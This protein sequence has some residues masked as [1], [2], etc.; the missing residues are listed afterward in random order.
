M[1]EILTTHFMGCS[2]ELASDEG[3]SEE[4]LH[5]PFLLRET[6]PQEECLRYWPAHT[7]D[8]QLT[9]EFAYFPLIPP[10]LL[11]LFLN[12]IRTESGQF[13]NQSKM[14]VD[15]IWQGGAIMSFH[16]NRDII[17]ILVQGVNYSFNPDK[18]DHQDP[19]NSGPYKIEKTLL[20]AKV[21]IC[22]RGSAANNVA[23]WKWLYFAK[24]KLISVALKSWPGC[25]Y[26][27]H[28][29]CPHALGKNRMRSFDHGQALNFE[30]VCSKQKPKPM[31]CRLCNRS[32]YSIG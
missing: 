29:P 21:Y 10:G 5:L 9:L 4:H 30:K 2:I 7:D 13:F 31:E 19:L 28:F 22:I 16:N 32:P 17:R 8:D 15:S 20:E 27:I 3:G 25:Q 24:E 1:K 11:S 12:A 23:M 14:E 6:V 26:T 18:V